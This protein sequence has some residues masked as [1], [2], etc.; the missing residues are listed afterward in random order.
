MGDEKSARKGTT[1]AIEILHKRFYAD[2][3]ER[4]A[5]LEDARLHA[6][7]ARQIYDLRTSMGLSQRQLA[8]LIGTS[9]SVISRLEDADYE[10]HSITMLSRITAALGASVSIKIKSASHVEIREGKART[11]RLIETDSAPYRE[12]AA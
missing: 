1:D 10:G 4:M 6:Q 7:I 11:K 3:P 12:R 5:A 9:P 8:K 2:D